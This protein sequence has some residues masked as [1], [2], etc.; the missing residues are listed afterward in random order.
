MDAIRSG[1]TADMVE[2]L[3]DVAFLILMIGKLMARAGGPSL[4]D[5]LEVEAA[6]MVR[7]H[8]HVFSDTTYENQSEQ[9]KDWDRIKR[10][11]RP[12]RTPKAPRDL[13]TARR[14]ACRSR[15]P[16]ASTPRPTAWASRGP[17]MKTSKSG[18]RPNG[19]SC[20]MRCPMTEAIEHEFA[21]VM[22]TT[23]SSLAAAKHQAPRPE[24]RH[25]TLP[26]PL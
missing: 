3:G 5:A 10:E 23:S 19:W 15:Q 7:R 14:A 13:M 21:T 20:S 17:K 16:T 22:F 2:E 4:A 6:K 25:R 11:E 18:S 12:L 1:K 24:R 26:Y 8:P 9:L